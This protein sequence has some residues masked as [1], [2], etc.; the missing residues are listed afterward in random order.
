MTLGLSDPAKANAPINPKMI[1]P[2][3]IFIASKFPVSSWVLGLGQKFQLNL[4][5]TEPIDFGKMLILSQ[6]FRAFC[7]GMGR[8]PNII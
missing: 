8:D 6:Q 3:G 1:T 4:I 2:N 7:Q 5:H